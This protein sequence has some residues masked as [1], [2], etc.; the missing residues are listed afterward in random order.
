MVNSETHVGP[1]L[2]L[3]SCP[4]SPLRDS[5]TCYPH[6]SAFFFYRW[7]VYSTG[8]LPL[9]MRRRQFH[10]PYGNV[11]PPAPSQPRASPSLHWYPLSTHPSRVDFS[12]TP[13]V[14]SSQQRRPSGR[15]D[16]RLSA[17]GVWLRSGCQC[18]TPRTA[19]LGRGRRTAP[20]AVPRCR[21]S[22]TGTGT[23]TTARRAALETDSSPRTCPPPQPADPAASS[24]PVPAQ[25]PTRSSRP[26]RTPDR[27]HQDPAPV[28]TPGFW[29]PAPAPTPA[30]AP[31]LQEPAPAPVP[32]IRSSSSDRV[33]R[34]G[35][36]R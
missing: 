11:T 30:P 13:P 19:G 29:D 14:E 34:R 5:L 8:N 23:G 36:S 4:C 7:R 27:D 31:G 10:Y 3:R 26:P 22:R 6:Q 35:S 12:G 24:V 32:G 17:R 2:P 16:C 18:P 33:R 25:R 15:R 20:Q 9:P 1:D 28:S 21:L